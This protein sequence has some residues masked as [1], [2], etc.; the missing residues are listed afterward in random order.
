[1]RVPVLSLE[2]RWFAALLCYT[3]APLGI[4]LARRPR[5]IDF[6]W[7]FA[8]AIGICAVAG[9]ALLP[10]VSARWWAPR[11]RGT[12]F[13]RLVQAT[14]RELSYV[15]LVFTLAHAGLLWVLEPRIV[16]YLLPGAIAPM[17]AGTGALAL[18]AFIV[19]S[20][21]HREALRWPYAGWRGWHAGLSCVLLGLLGWHVI[22]AGYHYPRTATQGTLC[23]LAAVPT[24]ATWWLRRHPGARGGRLAPAGRPVRA[25]R[26][27]LAIALTWI[28][29]AVGFGWSGA[30]QVPL[31]ERALCARDPCL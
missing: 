23:M 28:A 15:L 4:V 12:A 6:W 1:M 27:V 17:L 21:R 16:E 26:L 14:H 22:G 11:H 5:A 9:F 13:L 30:A 2:Q 19:V 24:F 3:L 10:L 31:E 7:D 25:P 20:S 29:A 18:G 8:M